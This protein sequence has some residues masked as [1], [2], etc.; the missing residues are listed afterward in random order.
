ASTKGRIVAPNLR[1]TRTVSSKPREQWHQLCAGRVRNGRYPRSAGCVSSASQVKRGAP[2]SVDLVQQLSYEHHHIVGLV[3]DASVL[4]VDP[5]LAPPRRRLD[6]VD[7]GSVRVL[8]QE[9]DPPGLWLPT[10]FGVRE[11]NGRHAFHHTWSR[12]ARKGAVATIARIS[13]ER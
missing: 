12:N 10:R 9:E 8:Q 2:L 13:K 4:I 3:I 7:R 6:K 1:H 11:D 5:P